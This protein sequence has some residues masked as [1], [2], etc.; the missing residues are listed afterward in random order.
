MKRSIVIAASLA[1]LGMGS[2]HAVEDG[3]GCGLGA[4]L[5]DGESGVAPQVL[6]VTTNGT[7]GSQTFGIS[8]G[9]LGCDPEGTIEYRASVQHY[10]GEQLDQ[11]AADMSAGGGDHL[12]TLAELMEIP[13]ADR[14]AF[15]ETT[16][17]NFS[18][19]FPQADTNARDALLNLQT[20]MREHARMAQ[21]IG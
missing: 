20:V 2:A 19:I 4:V 13:E 21:Y 16:Q 11:V 5:W 10:M 3:P 1:A 8:T 15:Y 12:G 17:A 14:K 18:R 9:T 6:A 7:A